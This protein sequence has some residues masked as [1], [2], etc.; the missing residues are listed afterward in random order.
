ML[1]GKKP[2]GDDMKMSAKKAV[3]ARKLPAAKGAKVKKT[4]AY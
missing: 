4:G 2:G 1:F 3:S